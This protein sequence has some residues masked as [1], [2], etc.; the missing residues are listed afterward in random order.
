MNV[1][2]VV[3]EIQRVTGKEKLRAHADVLIPLGAPGLIQLLG[4]SVIEQLGK[5]LIVLLPSRKGKSDGQFF[6]CVRLLGPIR[7]LVSDAVCR[8][9]ARLIKEVK[10]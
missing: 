3:V 10:K 6:D 9:Y 8:E 1:D 2:D 7:Q 5:G 4:C